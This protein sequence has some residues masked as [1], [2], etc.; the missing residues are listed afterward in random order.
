MVGDEG[1]YLEYATNI[2]HGYYSR[3]AP[4]IYLGVGPGYPL[5]L[6]PFLFLHIPL[7]FVALMNA[8]FYYF[9]IIL[10]YKALIR[11]VSINFAVA[12]SMFWALYYNAYE[13][14]PLILPET[15]SPFLISLFLYLLVKANE[16]ENSKINKYI[17]LS[18][19][20]FG[21]IALTK[22]IFGYVLLF[23]VAGNFFL[24]IADRNSINYRKGLIILLVALAT[25]MPYLVYTYHLTG[26]IYYW[27]TV[28]GNNL[29][30]M[31]TPYNEEYGGWFP[32]PL[33]EMDTTAKLV[34]VKEFRKTEHQFIKNNNNYIPGTDDYIRFNHLKDYEEIN[35]Y[36]GVE[37]DDVYKR[38]AFQNIKNHPLKFAENC[39]SNLGRIL[40]HYPYAYKPQK[41]HTLIRFPLNGIISVLLLFCIIP[42]LLNWKRMMFA[43]RFLLI[44]FFL[45][46]GGS[47]LGSAETRM[48]TVI[49]PILLLW[50]SYI[51]QRVLKIKLKFEKDN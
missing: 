38:I 36:T 45:Y 16:T 35:K 34:S 32:D 23:L 14:F 27:G 42:T 9:S 6:V 24:W 4:N 1:K 37:Q 18:G 11:I 47:L 15:I 33:P 44:V 20:T 40:F 8:F 51:L 49:V 13:F 22:I 30:W 41:P 43:I 19:I 21:Y 46:F 28:G 2:L 48:F 29:Y 31:S 26:R 10:L 17:Y 12:V 39:F 5:I 7:I 50:I 3:P 25:T